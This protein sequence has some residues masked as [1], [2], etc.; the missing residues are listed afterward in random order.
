MADSVRTAPAERADHVGQVAGGGVGGEE[1]VELVLGDG[2]E[3]DLD[4][5]LRGE[6]VDDLLGGGDPVGQVLQDP[7]GDAVGVTAAT[8]PSSSPPQAASRE[9]AT[10]PDAERTGAGA[11]TGPSGHA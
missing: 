10:R 1:L 2:D 8:P 3:L 5:A 11:R 4:P 6:G 7:D 9:A